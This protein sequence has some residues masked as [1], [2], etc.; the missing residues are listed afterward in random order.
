M[1]RKKLHR[2]HEFPY[3]ITARTNNREDFP[4]GLEGT[5]T[6]FEN[7]LFF[8]SLIYGLQIHASVLMPNHIHLLATPS[9]PNFDLGKAMNLLMSNVTRRSNALCNR[10]G[11]L[12]GGPY[13]WSIIQSSRYFGHAL[14]YV[15]RNPVKGKLCHLV[16]EYPF[17]TL[18]YLYGNR[19]PRHPLYPTQ[20]GLELHLPL[21]LSDGWLAWLNR[22]FPN[23]TEKL[24]QTGLSKKYF[25]QQMS[26]TSRKP[27]SDLEQLL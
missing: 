19:A 13:H 7:E 26:R 5:W 12:F 3:H 9:D 11:H 16:E 22:P 4:L 6:L 27:L 14:K 25:E 8:L 10:S 2:T 23:E 15:Y 1:P 24:I 20:M 21:A 18:Q 17:S